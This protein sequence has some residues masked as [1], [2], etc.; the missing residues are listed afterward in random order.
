[1]LIAHTFST[2]TISFLVAHGFIITVERGKIL[3]LRI[4]ILAKRKEIPSLK[5]P[6]RSIT[7]AIKTESTV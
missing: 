7:F 3:S 4:K 6:I 5:R 1:M 2:A